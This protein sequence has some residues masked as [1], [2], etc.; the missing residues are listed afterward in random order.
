MA[1]REEQ[2]IEGAGNVF[3]DLG[4]KEPDEL[5]ANAELTHL[6]YAELRDRNLTPAAA[7]RLLDIQEAEIAQLMAGRFIRLSTERLLHLLTALDRD[8]DII[9]RPR[10]ADRSRARLRVV[11]AAA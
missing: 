2:I 1:E 5:L 8:V 6:V 7:A 9:V 4:L 10:S 11:S 3:D